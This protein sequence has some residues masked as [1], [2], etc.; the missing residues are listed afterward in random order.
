MPIFAGT[1]FK[2]TFLFAS[3]ID[4]KIESGNY[5][6]FLGIGIYLL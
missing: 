1:P 4:I 6:S 5:K 3:D 2:K